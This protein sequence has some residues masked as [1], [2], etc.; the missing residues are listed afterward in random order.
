MDVTATAPAK[1]ADNSRPFCFIDIERHIKRMADFEFRLATDDEVGPTLALATRL[2]KQDLAPEAIVRRFHRYTGGAVWVR[3]D[4]EIT[5]FILSL[6]L[7]AAGEAGLRRGQFDPS[8]PDPDHV[9]RPGEPVYGVYCWVYGGVDRDARRAVMTASAV[10]R[11]EL[12][13]MLP[14]FARGATEDGA[15]SAHAL[16]MVPVPDSLPDLFV[17]EPLTELLGAA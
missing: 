5:G 15:R 2:L 11:V 14:T 8:N 7:S 6:P 4:T 12:V 10:L 1:T 17:Q 9:C 3:A 13:P 16:G